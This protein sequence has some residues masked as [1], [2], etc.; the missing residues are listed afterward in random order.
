M[1]KLS[2]DVLMPNDITEAPQQFLVI[3]ST[4]TLRNQYYHFTTLFL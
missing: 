2:L 4:Y 3:S 1:K